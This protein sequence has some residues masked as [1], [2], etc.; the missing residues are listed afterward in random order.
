MEDLAQGWC[1]FEDVEPVGRPRFVDDTFHCLIELYEL[2]KVLERASTREE[3]RGS[4]AAA[5]EAIFTMTAE[6]WH[7]LAFSDS[8]SSPSNSV[9]ESHVIEYCGLLQTS[10][11]SL[12]VGADLH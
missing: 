4:R 9:V 7:S 6:N 8:H 5:L 12:Y 2:V 11:T 10:K 1:A 3:A